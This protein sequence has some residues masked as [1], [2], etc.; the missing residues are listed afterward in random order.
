MNALAVVLVVGGLIT[1][2]MAASKKMSVATS[3]QQVNESI[4]GG[5]R[6]YRKPKQ[7]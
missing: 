7:R 1:L 4:Q 2:V 5:M 6:G 3:S